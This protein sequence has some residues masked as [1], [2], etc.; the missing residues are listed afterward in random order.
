M[1]LLFIFQNAGMPSQQRNCWHQQFYAGIHPTFE[2]SLQRTDSS[3]VQPY[4]LEQRTAHRSGTLQVTPIGKHHCSR[5][6]NEH[7]HTYKLENRPKNIQQLVYYHISKCSSSIHSMLNTQYN[8]ARMHWRD[9][10][11]ID[12]LSMIPNIDC[13]F[14]GIRH[15]WSRKEETDWERIWLKTCMVWCTGWKSKGEI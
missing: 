6:E 1:V 11:E 2:Q 5:G 12:A 10:L 4:N 7:T 13:A 15:P 3:T 8:T 9:L 14:L